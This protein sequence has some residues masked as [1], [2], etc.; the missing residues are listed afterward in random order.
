MSCHER[1]LSGRLRSMTDGKKRVAIACQGGGS[2]SVFTAGAL[3]ALLRRA[4][5]RYEFVAFSGASGGAI[6]A[7]LAWYGL[8]EGGAEE[9]CELLDEF[10]LRENSANAPWERFVNDSLV[11][12]VRWQQATGLLFEQSPGFWSDFWQRELRRSLERH[13]EFDDIDAGLVSRWSPQLFIGAVD[14][15]SGE[16][17]VFRSHAPGGGPGKGDGPV[18]NDDP[19]TGIS[20]RALLASAAVRPMFNGVR[21]GDGVY[22]DGLYSQ[23][24]P[25]R[26]LP[27][28]DP[29]EIWVIQINPNKLGERPRP[30]D[31]PKS[32]AGI[33]DRRNELAGNLSLNQELRFIEKINELIGAGHLGGSKYKH[34]EVREP[35]ENTRPLDAASK[36]DRGPDFIQEMMEAG[37]REAREFLNRLPST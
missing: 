34:V 31:E 12:W 36:L 7:L 20:A 29:D 23:N 26:E 10:W 22:W 30:G 16:F 21:I 18:F 14:V 24:P 17:A 3:Q 6:C 11:G 27:D 9:S 13:V 1:G 19:Y 2:H 25:V 33:L 37:A 4:G 15:L 35:I 8:L 32:V 5:E 28:A